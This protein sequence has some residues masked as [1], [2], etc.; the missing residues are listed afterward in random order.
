[1]VSVELF[2]RPAVRILG[3]HRVVP[4]PAIS[5][6]A[7]V[8]LYRKPDGK[9]HLSRAR[10]TL[11][12][13]GSWRARPTNGQEPH[14]LH[15]MS[16]SNSPIL[17]PDGHGVRAGEQISLLLIDPDRLISDSSPALKAP[18]GQLGPL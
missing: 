17:L 11:E 2:P 5:A 8:D 3:G 4:L 14:Q 13:R 16:E 6:T 18:H 1:M 9:L 10:L 7:D 15:S 12:D